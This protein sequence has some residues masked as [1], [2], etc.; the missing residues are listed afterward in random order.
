M[1]AGRGEDGADAD[2]GAGAGAEGVTEA[3][4]APNEAAD[5]AFMRP[6]RGV[7]VGWSAREEG[8]RTVAWRQCTTHGPAAAMF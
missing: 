1:L 8:E 7:S 6:L 5:M 2:A 4:D 3:P